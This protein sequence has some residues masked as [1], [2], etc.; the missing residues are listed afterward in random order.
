MENTGST[1]VALLTGAIVGAGIAI[2]YAPDK[3]ENT[4]RRLNDE[5]KKAKDR[6]DKQFTETSNRLGERARRARASFDSRL[7]ETLN[8][9]SHKADDIIDALESKL[10]ELRAKNA[11]LQNST[12]KAKIPAKKTTT[13]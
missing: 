5:A 12:A 9:A 11:K 1:L 10:E 7:D 4:R 6:L 2:L 3:G 8:S 13:A